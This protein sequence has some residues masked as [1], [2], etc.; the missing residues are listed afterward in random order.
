[1]VGPGATAAEAGF[2]AGDTMPGCVMIGSQAVQ[3][4]SQEDVNELVALS[5]GPVD[6]FLLAEE[7]GFRTPTSLGAGND[8][9]G[10]EGMQDC[11]VPMQRGEGYF[12]VSLSSP[13]S[14]TFGHPEEAVHATPAALVDAF[15][16]EIRQD[17]S[18]LLA[19]P[20]ARI[21][22]PHPKRPRKKRTPVSNPRRSVRLARG[23]GR[24]STASKQQAVIIKRLCLANEGEFIS[25]T[26]LE[27]YVDLFWRPLTD[28]HI[29][30]ILALFGWEPEAMPMEELPV[31]VPA[32]R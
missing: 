27:A 11:D 8:G 10:P 2:A 18:P 13:A 5:S 9:V 26:T 14:P 3:V 30:T 22:P 4:L 19:T 16:S 7:A 17:I 24:G 29:T 12:L 21:P 1:M 31:E 6:Q 28:A 20:H 23:A 15:R 32:G 25:D